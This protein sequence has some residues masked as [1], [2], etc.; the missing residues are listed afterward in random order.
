MS[1]KE[2]S[3]VGTVAPRRPGAGRVDILDRR[4]GGGLDDG[5]LLTAEVKPP[6]GT[7]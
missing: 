3:R 7:E 5:P 1:T 2:F 6:D 4:F